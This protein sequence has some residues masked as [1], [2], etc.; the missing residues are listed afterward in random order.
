[1]VKPKLLKKILRSMW[2]AK[3]SYFACVFV[4][5]IGIVCYCALTTVCDSLQYS[6]D[7]FYRDTR[8]ADAFATVSE[9][10]KARLAALDGIEGVA[11]VEGRLSETGRV[12]TEDRE[13]IVT[14]RLIGV[15]P[16]AAWTAAGTAAEASSAVPAGAGAQPGASAHAPA[17]AASSAGS[18]LN[19]Y[20]ADGGGLTEIDD[21]LIGK[22][23]LAARGIAPGDTIEIA[24]YGQARAFTV[25]GSVQSP[26][27]IYT[28]PNDGSLFPDPMT[29]DIAFVQSGALETISG[30]QGAAT[31]LA[32]ALESGYGFDDV[33]SPL[34]DALKNYGLAAL[35]SRDDQPSNLLVT[36]ELDSIASMSAPMSGLF[37]F[38]AAAILYIMLRRIVEQERTQIGTFKAFGYTNR[39]VVSAYIL[40]GL[41]TGFAGGLL[42]ALLSIPASGAYFDLFS[43][44]FNIPSVETQVN[45][46]YLFTGIGLAV[47]AGGAAALLGV[48]NII[49]LSPSDAMRPSAP[50]FITGSLADRVRF[51]PLILTKRGMMALRF[52]GRNKLKS[53]LI[54]FSIAIS[55]SVMSVTY[56]FNTLIDQMI[57]D[58]FNKSQIYDI[59]TVL[60]GPAA[61]EAALSAFRGLP[62][63]RDAEAIIELPVSVVHE[64]RTRQIAL[65][66]LNAGS[67]QFRI[68]DDQGRLYAPPTDGL[69]LTKNFADS[70]GLTRGDTVL[71]KSPLLPEDKPVRISNVIG[72]NFAS[73]CYMDA[74][75]LADFFRQPDFATAVV[76]L[77]EPGESARVKEA[78]IRGENVASVNDARRI[79]ENYRALMGSYISLIYMIL[80]MAILIAFAIIYNIS[81]ISL[82]ERQRELATMRVLGMTTAETAEVLTFEHW[83][84]FAAAVAVGIPMT[85]AMRQALTAAISNDL[86]GM[87]SGTPP[88]AFIYSAASCAISVFLSNLAARRQIGRFS[89]VEVLKERD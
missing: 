79:L 17:P 40:Y 87:P 74:A 32:F 72:T 37:L 13:T 31:D 16:Q 51:L 49:K 68:I 38:V 89:L 73:S 29:F 63:V 42:G 55:F 4:I 52:I 12:L 3:K 58:Q 19:M 71:I 59:K 84:L 65:T 67:A 78:L 25:K 30:R 15:D 22:A 81:S 47:A 53:A 8:F 80:L 36:Q 66:G 85:L 83:V 61:K 60:K 77:T 9:I 5:A 41:I 35:Y 33:K 39:E 18:A 21:I 11:G 2:G 26:E 70:M 20:L 10:P 86:Y 75:A 54:L 56:S 76:L 44:Y 24:L 7:N 69:I 46:R 14:L 50:A 57:Y 23:F 34:E 28:M 45:F 43:E 6:L 88:V 82:S 1:M 48:K 62:G 64:N 27:Y